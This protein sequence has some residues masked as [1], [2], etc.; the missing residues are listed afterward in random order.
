MKCKATKN[1]KGISKLFGLKILEKDSIKK[2]VSKL[3]VS[4]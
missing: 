3:P 4:D 1:K 2:I